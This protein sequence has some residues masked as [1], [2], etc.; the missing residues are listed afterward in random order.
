VRRLR[1]L[2]LDLASTVAPE[3]RRAVEDRLRRLDA[4]VERSIAPTD[5]EDA[6]IPDPQG[7]GLSR[8]A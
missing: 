5:R 2:F 3:R 6:R 4:A 8:V 7:L 1:R